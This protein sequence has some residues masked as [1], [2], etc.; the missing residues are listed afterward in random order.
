[1]K[2][3][4][5]IAALC[6]SAMLALTACS[7]DNGENTP[8]NDTAATT[9]VTTQDTAATTT[10]T[11][12]TTTT[13]VT[14]APKSSVNVNFQTYTYRFK[15]DQNYEYEATITLSP[16][17]L[18]SKADVLDAAWAKV[19]KGKAKPTKDSMGLQ[20]YSNNLYMTTLRSVTGS[21]LDDDFYATM[22]EMYFSVGTI[23]VKNV[24]NGWDFTESNPGIPNV[25]L[26]WASDNSRT[27][28]SKYS[29]ISK[30]YYSSS[31]SASVGH[32]HAV[33][34]MTKNSWGPV[35]IVLAHAENITPKYPNGQYRPEVLAGYLVGCNY[36]NE[37]GKTVQNEMKIA[38]PIYGESSSPQTTT[39]AQTTKKAQTTTAA[40]VKAPKGVKSAADLISLANSVYYK[41]FDTAGNTI[42]KSLNIKLG[43]HTDENYDIEERIYDQR[44]SKMN[45][46]GVSMSNLSLE[47]FKTKPN[48]SNCGLIRFQ[49]SVSSRKDAIVTA[50]KAKSAYDR[51]YKQFK[52]A[53]GDP[54][55]TIETTEA[56]SGE[57]SDY[58]KY[59]WVQWDIPSAGNVW[60]CWGKDLW[61]QQGYNDCI[62]SIFHP[63]RDKQ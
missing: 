8:T 27:M 38:I 44:S 54:T 57:K 7:E 51:L 53:Y 41:D 29:L 60:L 13:A 37:N 23:S 22:T 4:R 28:N 33:P 15:D 39:Q 50:S 61:N 47:G 43:S 6:A 10:T 11:A 56:G 17:I 45:V 24:T 62:L 55:S 46:M 36:W 12:A 25:V 20:A 31:E 30:T 58:S 49:M 21:I 32:L 14:T 59:Y 26:R 1:M 52:A 40:A 35:P 34:K 5:I 16:W 48:R 3:K 42:A 19:G 9:A 18:E 63:D 2:I